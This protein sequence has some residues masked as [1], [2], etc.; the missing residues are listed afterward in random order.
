MIWTDSIQM[1]ILYVGLFVMA[2]CASVAVG[3]WDVVWE[4]VKEGGRDLIFV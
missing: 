2:G 3:G 1:V 4:R